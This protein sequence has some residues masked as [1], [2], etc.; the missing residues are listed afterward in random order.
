MKKLLISLFL[1]VTVIF[2]VGCSAETTDAKNETTAHKTSATATTQ[3]TSSTTATTKAE[4]I[5]ELAGFKILID[6]GHGCT[7]EYVE[8]KYPGA[9]ETTVENSSTGATG[10]ATH[11]REGELTL[12]VALLLQEKLEKLGADVYMVRTT[13]GTEMSLR[14][15]AE[16]GNRLKVDL[17]FRIHADGVDDSSVRGASMLYPSADYVGEELSQTSEKAGQIIMKNY[18]ESTGLNDRGT[19]ARNDLVGFNFSEVPTVL[20]E[21][22]FMTNPDE[23]KLMFQEDFQQKMVKGI[24]E[25]IKEYNISK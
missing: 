22:G 18:I 12:Q 25:G 15:R 21:L 13:E 11:K 10:V 20:I 2:A 1:V 3:E 24:A 23:D 19:V 9:T 4:N 7:K 17:A 16:M 5:G 8:P 6:A 14:D